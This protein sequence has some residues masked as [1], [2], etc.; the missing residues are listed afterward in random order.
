M[1]GG[2][3]KEKKESRGESSKSQYQ[4]NRTTPTQVQE[5]Q[6][7]FIEGVNDLDD[8]VR[9]QLPSQDHCMWLVNIIKIHAKI[10][11]KDLLEEHKQ[12]LFNQLQHEVHNLKQENERLTGELV[13]FKTEIAKLTEKDS[14][15]KRQVERLEHQY[16]SIKSDLKKAN[17][18]LDQFEQE[19][20]RNSVQIVGLPDN[21]DED[22]L[23]Q[24]LKMTK[25][26]L[27]IKIKASDIGTISRLGK[28]KSGKPR[29][30]N[31]AFK[32]K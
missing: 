16:A 29:N 10:A 12:S 17:L 15:Q 5:D 3:K 7:D 6:E 27:G 30:L 1:A 32:V 25:D 2:K 11:A 9:A 31:I 26:K 8:D 19:N 20:Y 21:N 18:K 13:Q 22:D 4:Q 24:V 28:K 23:K 14:K